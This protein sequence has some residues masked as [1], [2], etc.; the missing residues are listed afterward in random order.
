[1]TDYE[2]TMNEVIEDYDFD[3]M[4]TTKKVIRIKKKLLSSISDDLVELQE[5]DHSTH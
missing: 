2:Q 3:D 1:M 4:T 5:E